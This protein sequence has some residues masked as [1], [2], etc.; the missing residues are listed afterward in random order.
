MM[1]EGKIVLKEFDMLELGGKKY[2]YSPEY[3]AVSYS[4]KHMPRESKAV[5]VSTSCANNH[6]GPRNIVHHRLDA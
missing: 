6:K 1:K 3:S 4:N 2:L 5:R